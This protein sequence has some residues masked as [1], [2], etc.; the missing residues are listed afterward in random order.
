MPSILNWVVSSSKYYCFALPSDNLLSNPVL[1]F[2]FSDVIDEKWVDIA[3]YVLAR[4]PT[5]GPDP[6]DESSIWRRD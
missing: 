4:G 6:T 1:W 5:A 2:A 3:P